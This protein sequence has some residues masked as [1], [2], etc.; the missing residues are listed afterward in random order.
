MCN[1]INDI[2]IYDRTLLWHKHIGHISDKE[3]QEL[4]ETSYY[5]RIRSKKLIS[6]NIVLQ[7][8]RKWSSFI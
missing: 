8:N 1:D 6:V 3:M 5:T 4:S 2:A 7:E